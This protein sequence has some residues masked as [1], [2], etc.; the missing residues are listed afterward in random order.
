MFDYVLSIVILAIL[1]LLAGAFFLHR[2]GARKQAL[3]M[4]VLAVVMIANVAIWVIPTAGGDSLADAAA[5][6]G[7]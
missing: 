1:A 6:A 2:R 7:D 5:R 3:L 4:V